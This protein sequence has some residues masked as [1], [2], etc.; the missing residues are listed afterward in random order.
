MIEISKLPVFILSKCKGERENDG[1]RK[2]TKS[3]GC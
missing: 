2:I 3:S 1:T